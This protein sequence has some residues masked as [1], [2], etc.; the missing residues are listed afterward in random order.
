MPSTEPVICFG[1]QP[2]GF[3][4]RRFLWAKIVTAKRLQREIGGRIVFF[5]HDS[6]HDPRETQTILTDLK[7][8]EEQKLNF[9]FANRL[10][11]KYAPLYAKQ[12]DRQWQAQMARQLPKY[13][14]EPQVEV[15]AAI[16]AGNVADFCLEMYRTLNLLDGV[17]VVRSSDRAFRETACAVEDYFVDVPH[18]GEIVRARLGE[19]GAL[20]LHKGG[21]AFEDLPAQDY[22]KA[23]ISPTRDTRLRWMQSVIRCT[24]YIAGAGEM[25]YLDTSEAP[26]IAFVSRDPI[27]NSSAAYIP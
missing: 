9:T 17:E 6:D 16:Q 3:L 5:Y 8:G 21:N 23:Q 27:D 14:P 24:H 12:V 15:F 4:P 1:Q 22:G 7:T 18:E 10:Q 19:N 26:E 25:N 2:C 13:L 11:K 20:R